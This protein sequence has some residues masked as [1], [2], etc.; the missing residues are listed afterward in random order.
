VLC[1]RRTKNRQPH[2][3][4]SAIVSTVSGQH[5]SRRRRHR[6]FVGASR[7]CRRPPFFRI[8]VEAGQTRRE[9]G[10]ALRFSGRFGARKNRDVVA[11]PLLPPRVRCNSLLVLSRQGWGRV[12]GDSCNRTFAGISDARRFHPRWNIEVRRRHHASIRHSLRR[13]NFS[14]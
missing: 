4:P 13:E 11:L 9:R 5:S 6:L 8:A 10:I 2:D 3:A 12:A 7:T 14:P 1:K